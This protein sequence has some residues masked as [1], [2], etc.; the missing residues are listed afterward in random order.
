MI[1]VTKAW[2]MNRLSMINTLQGWPVALYNTNATAADQNI[3]HLLFDKDSDGYRLVEI[4]G[5]SGVER[6][7]SKRLSPKD[8]DLYLDG[9]IN[10]IS[11]YNA[12]QIRAD[13]KK[14]PNN[15]V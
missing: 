2:L 9:I 10:G 3:G 1:K 11:L 14:A 12:Q 8:M 5:H 6:S 4:I 7:W 13:L 15:A